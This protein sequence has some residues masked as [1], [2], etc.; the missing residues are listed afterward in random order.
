MKNIIIV[1]LCFLTFSVSYAQDAKPTKQE[2]MDWIAGKFKDF[3]NQS[4]VFANPTSVWHFNYKSYDNGIIILE[5]KITARYSNDYTETSYQTLQIDL[6]KIEKLISDENTFAIKGLQVQK[7]I[8]KDET[9][10]LNGFAL[11][12]KLTNGTNL[13]IITFDDDLKKRFEKA[14]RVLIDYNI[15]SKP[16]EKF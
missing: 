16:K 7:V 8:D 11:S 5:R 9:K 12:E 2:T 10:F 1:L 4:D 3:I 15:E 13:S 6:N 14:F